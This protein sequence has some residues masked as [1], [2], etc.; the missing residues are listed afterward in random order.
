ME[1]T[2]AKAAKMLRRLNEE[3]EALMTKEAKS[4]SYTAVLGENAEEYRPDYA[5]EAMQED[6]EAVEE[7][8]RKLKHAISRFNIGHEIEEFGM[9]IDEMLVYIP[10]LSARKDKLEEMA[11]RLPREREYTY[12]N[13]NIA[14]YRYANYDISSAE[15]AYAECAE[16]LARAQNALDRV[17]NTVT[18]EVDL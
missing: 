14:E 4:S 12:G 13:S 6:L 18:F 10:Q 11:E 5:F 9:H 1:I 15:K 17:N 7:K 2:S 3:H 16:L 8:I